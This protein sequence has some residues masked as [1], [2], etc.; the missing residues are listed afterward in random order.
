LRRAAT[1]NSRS[2]I[3]KYVTLTYLDKV[4]ALPFRGKAA[5]KNNISTHQDM[6]IYCLGHVIDESTVIMADFITSWL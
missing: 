2:T 3:G 1:R 4:R 5:W 6:L